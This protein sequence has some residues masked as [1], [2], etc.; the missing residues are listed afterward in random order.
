MPN[1]SK[2]PGP[3]PQPPMPVTVAED[4]SHRPLSVTYLGQEL[5]VDYID[6]EWQDDAETWELKPVARLY[7]QVALEDGQRLLVF[8]NMDTNSW[9]T[10]AA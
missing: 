3:R 6:Q 10:L 5:Q 1:R 4:G 8:K 2:A 7:Y 9:Y